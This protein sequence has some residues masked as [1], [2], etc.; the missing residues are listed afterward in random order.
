LQQPRELVDALNT[1][2]S[3]GLKAMVIIIVVT[4]L[5]DLVRMLLGGRRTT[6]DSLP[7]DSRLEH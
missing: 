4:V 2:L 7:V 5:V 6:S 3:I 1:A